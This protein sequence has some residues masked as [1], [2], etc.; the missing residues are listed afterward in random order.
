MTDDD[1]K[2][3]DAE[4]DALA[5]ACFAL[6][7]AGDY[8]GGWR[9]RADGLLRPEMYGIRVTDY[10]GAEPGRF[11]ADLARARLGYLT[12]R[13]GILQRRARLHAEAHEARRGLERFGLDN[14]VLRAAS[15]P[16]ALLERA[17]ERVDRLAGAR[18]SA[19]EGRP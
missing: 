7:P 9:R 13:F 14:D 11:T 4:A 2:A 15:A 18:V 16:G 10:V 6:D 1:V 8:S 19:A 12:E 3:V 5:R 17:Q